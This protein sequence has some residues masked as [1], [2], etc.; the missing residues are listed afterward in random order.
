MR[1]AVIGPTGAGKGAQVQRLSQKLNHTRISTGELIR[2]QIRAGTEI[3]KGIEGHHNRGEAVP[4]E[5]VL[6]L[7][8]PRL[9]PAGGWI[10]DGYPRNLAQARGLDSVLEERGTSGL[11]RVIALEGLEEEELVERV[12]SG[13]RHSQATDMVYHLRH[14]PPPRPADRTDPGPFVVRPDDT[15]EA[16]R[17]Q[18][19]EYLREAEAIKERYGGRGILAVV[20]ARQPI[21]KV[22]EDILAALGREGK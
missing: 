22:T 18:L 15:E 14:D 6:Q 11:S 1:L 8:L 20:N 16:V 17:R 10:L 12:T 3:G 21:E 9:Q 13:R 4:D 2:A 5:V 7:L 19:E